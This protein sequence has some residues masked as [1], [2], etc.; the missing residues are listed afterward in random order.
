MTLPVALVVGFVVG[1]LVGMP[2]LRFSRRLPR[3]RDLR[4]RACRCRRCREATRTSPAAPTGS[5]CRHTPALWLYGVALGVRGD[6]LRARLA[7]PARPHRPC[8]RA[9]RDSE[10]A[11]ASSGVLAAVYKT[12]AFGI[13]AAF[14]GVAG[15]LYVL[16]TNFVQPG[17]LRR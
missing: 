5:H 15:S 9:V 10:I 7:D 17:R 4:A 6:H 11:A 14:A 8:F 12:L 3:A 13:S 1:V 16:V 2:A